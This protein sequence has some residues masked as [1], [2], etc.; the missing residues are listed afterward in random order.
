MHVNNLH[1]W[2]SYMSLWL[3]VLF[4]WSFNSHCRWTGFPFSQVTAVL[5]TW[6]LGSYFFDDKLSP[7]MYTKYIIYIFNYINI[8]VQ[9]NNIYKY[10]PIFAIIVIEFLCLSYIPTSALCW[11]RNGIVGTELQPVSVAGGATGGGMMT[12]LSCGRFMIG[13]MTI[14]ASKKWI[15][16]LTNELMN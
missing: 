15:D 4:R 12:S 16:K 11:G 3:D 14:L 9:K 13:T 5:C 7:R 1:V 2:T 10:S 6:I 8:H